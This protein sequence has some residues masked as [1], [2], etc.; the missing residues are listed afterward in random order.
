MK[1]QGGKDCLSQEP[2]DSSWFRT[3]G[4]VLTLSS[5]QGTAVIGSPLVKALGSTSLNTLEGTD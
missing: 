2:Q 1:E 5:L 4:G 3:E